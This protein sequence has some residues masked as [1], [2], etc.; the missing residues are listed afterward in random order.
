MKKRIADLIKI[1]VLVPALIVSMA[2][3]GAAKAQ[4]KSDDA[5]GTAETTVKEET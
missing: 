2:A 1:G 3:C 5:A 4:G